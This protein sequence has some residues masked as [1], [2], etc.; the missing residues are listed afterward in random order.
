MVEREEIFPQ[1]P[2]AT[3]VVGDQ[4]VVVDM[5]EEEVD[6]APQPVVKK[7]DTIANIPPPEVK[8]FGGRQNASG[9]SS[10]Q[11]TDSWRD[12]V[13]ASEAPFRE[14]EPA[15]TLDPSPHPAAES[16]IA[17][18]EA[19]LTSANAAVDD[20]KSEFA[21][22]SSRI[23]TL[24]D[25]ANTVTQVAQQLQGLNATV[26]AMAEHLSGTPGYGAQRSFTCT[27]CGSQGTV[28]VPMKCTKCNQDN[29]MG[30]FPPQG[31]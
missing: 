30:W 12:Q 22:I 8:T 17:E 7:L 2:A 15:E 5:G 28:A 24:R 11:A 6:D 1:D 21:H 3:P 9:V 16:K 31:Q 23:D 18:L 20:L 19:A 4:G 26:S 25:T 27:H 13:D 10:T 14:P 29:L